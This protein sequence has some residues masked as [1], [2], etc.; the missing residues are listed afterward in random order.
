MKKRR[1][2]LPACNEAMELPKEVYRLCVLFQKDGALG[3][4]T[5]MRR[6]AACLAPNMA[7]GAALRGRASS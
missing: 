6:E 1:R 4:G 3:F 7:D 5:Q 2:S